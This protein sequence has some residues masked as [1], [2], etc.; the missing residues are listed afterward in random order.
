MEERIGGI[1]A[2]IK[3]LAE[4]VQ[5]LEDKHTVVSLEVQGLLSQQDEF[6]TQQKDF[7]NAMRKLERNLE[8]MNDNFHRRQSGMIQ[9]TSVHNIIDEATITKIRGTIFDLQQQHT[10]F[11]NEI[12]GLLQDGKNKDVKFIK[13]A[14]NIKNLQV[15]CE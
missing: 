13:M 3:M 5:K 1:K 14:E 11:Q 15:R 7:A 2:E 12:D 9:N 6:S 4:L 8:D 10:R